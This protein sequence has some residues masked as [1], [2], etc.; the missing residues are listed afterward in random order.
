MQLEALL[1]EMNKG[2]ACEPTRQ[3]KGADLQQE[4]LLLKQPKDE[5]ACRAASS[6]QQLSI[7]TVASSGVRVSHNKSVL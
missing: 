6:V 1:A 4:L 5:G 7:V 2:L 3:N